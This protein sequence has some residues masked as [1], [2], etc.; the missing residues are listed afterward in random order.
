MSKA[1]ITESL[2][3]NISKA[4]DST[5]K[6][7]AQM[8]TALQTAIA[9][10]NTTT[11]ESDT[12]I[13][14]AVASLSNGYGGSSQS[15]W[16][17]IVS[18]NLHDSSADVANVYINNYTETSYNGWSATGYIEVTPDTLYLVKGTFPGN[19]YNAFYKTDRSKSVG[20]FVIPGVPTDGYTI[21]RS[22][23]DAAYLRMSAATAQVTGIEL[24][25]LAS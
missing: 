10:A 25:E 14:D 4:I 17:V 21:I 19:Q 2:L 6:T 22:P 23:S 13:V 20:A 16:P 15:E 5:D 11:G 7:P 12:T 1:L 18:E 24:Y 3:T 8:A 9:S